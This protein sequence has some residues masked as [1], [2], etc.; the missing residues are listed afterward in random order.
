MSRRA[1]LFYGI[2]ETHPLDEREDALFGM[3]GR[4]SLVCCFERVPGVSFRRLSPRHPPRHPKTNCF[5]HRELDRRWRKKLL[6]ITCMRPRNV[7]ARTESKRTLQRLNTLQEDGMTRL[8][9]KDL[10][11]VTIQPFRVWHPSRMKTGWRNRTIG[12]KIAIK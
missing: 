6:R 9:G 5:V 7:L 8:Y 3:S 11:D 1:A 2:G 10:P 4:S 12:T